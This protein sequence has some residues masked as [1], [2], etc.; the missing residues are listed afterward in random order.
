MGWHVRGRPCCGRSQG[1]VTRHQ[2]ELGGRRRV[3]CQ[4]PA[5]PCLGRRGAR[6][7]LPRDP[8][9]SHAGRVKAVSAGS[10]RP[11]FPGGRVAPGAEA[12]RPDLRL[13]VRPTAK[14]ST[15]G[16]AREDQETQTGRRSAP[17]C[18]A[19]GTRCRPPSSRRFSPAF[20]RVRP[21]PSSD[22]DC[23]VDGRQ[24]GPPGPHVGGAPGQQRPAQ[25]GEAGAGLGRGR[26]C[27]TVK[28]LFCF[29]TK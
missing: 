28:R 11:P 6:V 8:G 9:A 7:A 29:E 19:R 15:G 10:S 16:S 18:P 13:E 27:L 20:M 12:C 17:E 2:L 21:E 22:C 14:G 25:E 24:A 26:V 5:A 23:A 4:L 3:R 1:K